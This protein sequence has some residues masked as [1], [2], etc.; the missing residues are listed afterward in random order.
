MIRPNGIAGLAV[1]SGILAL[2][3]LPSCGSGPSS[4]PAPVSGSSSYTVTVQATS[5]AGLGACPAA[6]AVGLVT[7]ATDAGVAYSLYRCGG[8]G[9]SWSPITCNVGQAG[10]VAYIPG[11]PSTLFVCVNLAWMP[12]AIPA[13]PA[14]PQGDAGPQG[15]S[16][17]QGPQGDA[18]AQGATGPQ[19]PAG[20]TG[21]Q[22]DTGA[23]GPEGDAGATGAQ[24]L[25]GSQG[26]QGLQGPQGDA[27]P[28]GNSVMVSPEPPG[29]N[30]ANGGEKIQVVDA[31]GN[32]IANPVYVCNGA[33]GSSA[34]CGDGIVE[35]SE[36][37]DT[38]GV[39][40][41]T[42][43]RNC[44]L[45]ICGDGY[46][47]VAAGE[48]C[49]P[50]GTAGCSSTCRTSSSPCV[51][52]D[53][54]HVAGTPD[55]TTGLCS[56]PP[57]TDGTACDDG[58]ACTQNDSCQSGVCIG[59]SAPQAPYAE[60]G[61]TCLDITT[62][63]NNCGGCGRICPAGGTCTSG[64]CVNVYSYTGADQT[65]QVPTASCGTLSFELWGAGGGEVGGGGGYTQASLT[66][67][68]GQVFTLIVGQGGN[69]LP[70][71]T[72]GGGGAGN[73]NANFCG[74]GGGRSAVRLAT[75]EELT[76]GGG[77][78]GCYGLSGGAG[79]G[80]SGGNGMSGNPPPTAPV[81]YGG[82]Q[83]AGGTGSDPPGINNNGQAFQGGDGA[84]Q[85]G[86]GGGGYFG[87]GGNGTV[88]GSGGNGTWF[89]G[90]GGGSGYCSTSVPVMTCATT[91]GS[92][93]VSAHQ[94]GD[95]V[96]PA[97][98]GGSSSVKGGD[99]LIVVRCGN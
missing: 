30:C 6:G 98:N 1:T 13:G 97:G 15:V 87:G 10:S 91:A 70:T 85:G 71:R 89:G 83:T 73:I 36:Q 7:S 62:D 54:C 58:N 57:V 5:V 95:W 75:T 67:T 41:A 51:A 61:G 2:A 18:G 79:G 19:G 21:P 56:N 33:S 40:T 77:G 20:P 25:A 93:A 43:N 34:I 44:T 11:T 28:Q 12:V 80:I 68:A 55:L 39:D 76:A 92:G 35:G 23:T 74:Q 64:T 27:G 9:G 69:A 24:G 72:Y 49:E 31:N 82:T 32:P 26:P 45:A 60:C 84:Y 3:A 59:T 94:L 88:S 29:T 78:G 17:P 50:P 63:T 96:G 81:A 38:G 48:Q 86:G 47:N 66:P 4:T 46:V 8:D 16:G 37:C 22:G 52:V 65:Y 99:G 90:G 42:C 14:G 53:Q